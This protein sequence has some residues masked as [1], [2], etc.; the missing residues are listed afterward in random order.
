MQLL[1]AL[2]PSLGAGRQ[3]HPRDLSWTKKGPGRRHNELTG[4][5]QRAKN[6]YG[7]DPR[8]A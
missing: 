2:F 6:A 1:L 3:N 4:A 5:Q 7:Y 8:R